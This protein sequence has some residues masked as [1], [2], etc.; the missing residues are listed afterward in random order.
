MMRVGILAIVGVTSAQAAPSRADAER[1]LVLE[2]S[3]QSDGVI[4]SGEGPVVSLRLRNRSKTIAHRAVMPGDGSDR[5]GWRE[6]SIYYTAERQAPDK[7]WQA[8]PE[9]AAVRCGMYDEE[10]NDDA[11]ELKAG[12][13]KTL[14]DWVPKPADQLDFSQSGTYRL[15]AHYLYS[16]GQ[17]LSK[18]EKKV[19]G[20]LADAPAFTLVS[21]PV[22]FTVKRGLDTELVVKDLAAGKQ[23]VKPETFVELKL[24][25]HGRDTR[26]GLKGSA[27]P[28]TFEVVG[29]AGIAVEEVSES[30]SAEG[31][32]PKR[33]APGQTQPVKLSTMG[34]WF[35]PKRP[36]SYQVRASLTLEEGGKQRTLLSRWQQ[37]SV[38]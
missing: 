15:R 8:T 16:A 24:G 7:S 4:D 28:V 38:R 34:W 9:V 11:F 27:L 26:K 30:Y 1:D 17:K 29:V 25:N 23:I 10:W 33:L 13:S 35:A 21:Q 20:F 37:F 3:L 32:P 12:D 14:G 19:G 22:E 36:G 5:Q 31:V 2:L 18:G 6:P